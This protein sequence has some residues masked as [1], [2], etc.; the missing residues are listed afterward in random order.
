M[1]TVFALFLFAI[2]NLTA[3]TNFQYVKKNQRPSTVSTFSANP[4]SQC[5]SNFNVTLKRGIV[6]NPNH[7][8]SSKVRTQVINGQFHIWAAGVI[9]E[10]DYQWA[11]FSFKPGF[12]DKKIK[13]VTVKY[14]IRPNSKSGKKATYIS[15]TRMI[16]G[17]TANG[18]TVRID[19]GQNLFGAG[20][21]RA[22]GDFQC[23]NDMKTVML[24]LVMQPGT[25]IVIHSLTVHFDCIPPVIVDY[26]CPQG[27][28]NPTIQLAGK[29]V[30]TTSGGTFV[31]Y[32]IPV[33]NHHQYPDYLFAADSYLPPCGANNNSSRTWVDIFDENNNRIY[34]FCA[35]GQSKNLKNIWF[36]V[37]KGENP[38][39]RVRIVMKDRGC[40][41]EYPS[42]WISIQ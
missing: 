12:P 13:G 14:S 40:Q 4:P 29:E 9:R 7:T 11:K 10:Q 22:N 3:Q 36:A 1:I 34:G 8:K 31:R 2:G 25:K 33:M 16:Q 27:L 24:K 41:K 30:Y 26:F 19:D 5:Q 17:P 18:G 28:P 6:A 38:P 39:K 35:L 37:K 20:S 21:H 23:G 42:N 15:Q 32:R